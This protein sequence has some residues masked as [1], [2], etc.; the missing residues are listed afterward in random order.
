[1]A[2][3]LQFP[4]MIPT[5]GQLPASYQTLPIPQP[6]QANDVSIGAVSFPPAVIPLPLFQGQPAGNILAAGLPLDIMK[7]QEALFNVN[8]GQGSNMPFPLPPLF[9]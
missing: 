2:G 6:V 3:V 1:M 4:T 5:N 8:T 7:L 9:L